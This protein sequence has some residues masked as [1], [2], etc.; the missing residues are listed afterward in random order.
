MTTILSIFHLDTCLLFSYSFPTQNPL[1]QPIKQRKFMPAIIDGPKSPLF[2]PIPRNTKFS[3]LPNLGI[4]DVMAEAVQF[5]PSG[6]CVCTGIPFEVGDPIFVKDQPVK[7]DFKPVTASWLV[8]MHTTDQRPLETNQQGFF[9][10]P[11]GTGV[12]AEHACDYFFVYSDGT[13]E[14]AVIKRRHQIGMFRDV[15]REACFEAV[16]HLKPRQLPGRT[17]ESVPNFLWGPFQT[18]ANIND[19]VRPW[20][21]WIWAWENPHPEKQIVSLRIEPAEG[22][23]IIAGISAG[24]VESPPTRWQ[25]RRKTVLTL[26][27]GETFDPKLNDQGQPKQIQ[28]DMG[29]IILADVRPIY[30]NDTWEET[31]NNRMPRFSP[32][33]VLVEYTAH[34]QAQFH[35]TGGKTVPVSELEEKQKTEMLEVVPPSEQ[36]VKLKTIDKKSGK[37]LAVKLHIHGEF[38]EYLTPID[39]QRVANPSWFQDYT[40]D[41]NHRPFAGFGN[42][43][44]ELHHCT[45]IPGEATIKLP[46]GKIYIEVSKG[47]EIRPV[48]KVVNVTT[49]T[50][51]IVIELDKVLHW[52]ERG[53]VTAD[54]HVHFLSPSSAQLEGAGEG[55]NIVNLLAS[56][57]GELMT[58]VG[59]FDGKTVFGSK[60]AGGDGEY[61]VRVGTENRQHILGHISLLG[62]NGEMI[63][64]LC[65]GGPGESSIGDPVEM[66]LTEW[67][68]QCKKQD[69]VVII[70]HFPGPRCEHAATIVTG[71]ADGIEM[72][73]WADLYSGIH[74]YSISDWYRYLNCGYMTAAVGGTDKMSSDTAVGAVRTY[75]V[76]DPDQEFTYDSWKE[77]VRSANT[78]VTY[79]PLMEFSVEGK[80]PGSRLNLSA[81]GGTVDVAWKVASVTIPMS[82]VDLIVNGEIR[83]SKELNPEADEGSWTV[84][85]DKSSW[86]AL[87]IRG[88]YADK[89]EIIAAH[90]SP[91]MVEVEGSQFSA[92]ADALTIL[93]QIEGAL[94]FIDT[95][96]TRADTET[97]KRMR[98]VLT[99]AHRELHNRMH[100]LGQYHEHSPVDDHSEHH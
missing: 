26:P 15:M 30:P 46:W 47:F 14:K 58:N 7:I 51:E 22:V 68:V 73:S 45:Y 16:P 29:T 71:N 25:S 86:I 3:D 69:G 52:R 99:S 84:N 77:A 5:S 64:P 21:N 27:D 76:I 10:H 31:Y 50:E 94:A 89:P 32:N 66:L 63:L 79:G 40:V 56:Q 65:T 81:S 90:S 53:W 82:R 37:P 74:P 80:P 20:M 78:F 4:S 54:T 19:T 87:L 6:S 17:T 43:S 55:V 13:E 95:V 39:R 34:P 42:P 96:G 88:H 67:G 2:T 59:D 70:P 38:D 35:L 8:F 9:P 24:Q 23:V 18:Y 12:L 1:P 72:T 62:Y 11:K 92:A 98:L 91:V 83:E 97:Y 100:Q 93:E 33:Q 44:M 36:V 85:I 60:E 57:W 48:R 49:E 75:A 28:L 61:L 41:Y